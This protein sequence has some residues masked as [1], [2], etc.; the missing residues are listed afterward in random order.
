MSCPVGTC[1]SNPRF[2]ISFRIPCVP[3]QGRM[4]PGCLGLSSCQPRKM[5]ETPCSVLAGGAIA[6]FHRNLAY[7]STR[8]QSSTPDFFP[9][10]PWRTVSAPGRVG[11]NCLVRHHGET[12]QIDTSERLENSILGDLGSNFYVAPRNFPHGL[13]CLWTIHR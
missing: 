4:H 5:L 8:P 3:F 2:L 13:Y 12:D 11:R 1:S 6:R 10:S 9:G 7:L